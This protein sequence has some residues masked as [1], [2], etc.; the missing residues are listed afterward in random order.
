[1]KIKSCLPIICFLLV[2]V[3]IN[4]RVI[5]DEIITSTESTESIDGFRGKNSGDEE[6]LI[7]TFP[8]TN[9]NLVSENETTNSSTAYSNIEKVEESITAETEEGISVS[10]E[11]AIPSGRS[12]LYETTNENSVRRSTRAAVLSPPIVKAED[13]NTPRKDFIDV[14]SH[15]G[16]ISIDNYLM[17]KQ[18][19]VKGVVVKLTEYTTYKN[20]YA[21]KQIENAQQAGLK[22]SVYHYS[23]FTNESEAIAEANYFA[24]FAQE[25]GLSKTTLMVND[26]EEPK[27]VDKGNHTQNSLSFKERLN[28]LGYGN[29]IHYSG[30]Y[31][32]TEGLMDASILGAKNIWVA[33]YPYSLSNVQMYSQYGAWQWS[34]LVTFPNLSTSFDMSSDYL[35][36]FTNNE[37]NTVDLSKYYTS[38]PNYIIMKKNDYI[39]SKLS[40]GTANRLRKVSKNQVIKIKGIAYDNKTPRLITDDGYLTA[41]K[42]YVQKILS[43]YKNYMY[44]LP[45][46]G[47]VYTKKDDYSYSNV[48]FTSRKTKYPKGSVIKVKGIAYAPDGCPRLILSDG[49][50]FTAN[51]S[52]VSTVTS[53]YNSYLLSKP[54]YVIFNKDD[55]FYKD[56]SF[57]IRG[58]KIKKNQVLKVNDVVFT[59]SG[60]PRLKGNN[61]YVTANKKYVSKLIASYSNYYYKDISSVILQKNDYFYSS[62]NFSNDTRKKKATKGMVV[63]VQGIEFDANGTPRLR[64]NQGYLSAKKTIVKAK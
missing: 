22:V 27:I 50:Y 56:V 47:Y 10:K 37:N 58:A 63:K 61:G 53:S 52:R 39:Y 42:S 2:L 55:Y 46:S 29:V 18:Y 17:M 5:S 60:V 19:G 32:I 16:E 31:W 51:L 26:I 28:E 36:I 62:V 6:T 40:F 57:K 45:S 30:L 44:V 3:S 11:Y 49:S 33:A 34:S 13:L 12:D 59:S 14:S 20:P 38:N 23:W 64:T 24:A 25:L 54:Q 1:M 48:S 9:E 43:S 35:G 7:S 8:S 15:N 4:E 21:K 41:N